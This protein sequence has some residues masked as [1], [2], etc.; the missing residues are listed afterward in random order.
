MSGLGFQLP[1]QRWASRHTFF[2]IRSFA[3]KSAVIVSD[4]VIVSSQ[5]LTEQSDTPTD[6]HSLSHWQSVAAAEHQSRPT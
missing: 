2:G 6:L 1:G 3:G 4:S 5:L